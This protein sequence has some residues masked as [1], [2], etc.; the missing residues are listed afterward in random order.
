MTSAVQTPPPET[1]TCNVASL[2]IEAAKL[3][4]EATAIIEHKSGRSITFGE[5]V[6]RIANIAEGLTNAGIGPGTRTVF[7]V[8]PG[9]EFFEGVFALFHAGAIPVV[10]DPGMGRKNLLACIK[11]AEPEALLGIS[12]AHALSKVFRSAFKTVRKRVTVGGRW[13]WGGE[14]MSALAQT[15]DGSF[16]V[17][18]TR[19][20]DLAAI[21]FTSG[22][23]G[24]PKGVKYEHGMFVGQTNAIQQTYG[25]E[26]GE[27]DVP[28]F[29]LFALFSVAMGVTVVLPNMDMSKPGS[30]NPANVVNAV[31]QHKATMS[32]ASPAVWKKVGPYLQQHDKKMSSLKRILIAGAPVPY[33]TLKM[34][35]GRLADDGDVFTPYGATESLPLSSIAASTI[36]GETAAK[37]AAGKGTCVG[38]L[39]D[40]VECKIVR[41]TE[42]AINTLDDADELPAGE[43]GEVIVKSPVTTQE[44]FQRPEKTRLAKIDDGSPRKW[45]RMGDS[46]YFD[47]HGRLWFCGRATH[48]VETSDGVMY[49]V[50]VE[51]IFNNHDAVNRSALVGIGKRPNQQPAIVIELNTGQLPPED[52]KEQLTKQL[53]EMA[54]LHDLTSPVKTAL[55]HKCLPVDV[56][57]NAKINR[58]AL[59][60]WA[61]GQ[62][63]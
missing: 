47:E 39:L 32:F 53:L 49:P 58:E 27:I 61:E 26:A 51:A 45:H 62:V 18:G 46:A 3:R 50:Q 48:R 55:F 19:N 44:Y 34:F 24:I 2:L 57:H 4:P 15:G 38:K 25:I 54:Q 21:L 37:T 13:F 22:A 8:K 7:A 36:L 63:A 5:L 6:K 33:S 23:T 40:M 30:A 10:V 35:E 28:C 9:I 14:S 60:A 12:A 52:L 56:R 42:D 59:A 41:L 43:I 11:E 16:P 29:A 17:A 20:D 31:N 1:T